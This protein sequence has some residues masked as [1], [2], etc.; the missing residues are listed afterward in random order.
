M[1]PMPAR[2]IVQVQA[3]GLVARIRCLPDMLPRRQRSIAIHVRPDLITYQIGL[4]LLR[5][6]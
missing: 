4:E 6:R 5:I 2:P 3:V 1:R